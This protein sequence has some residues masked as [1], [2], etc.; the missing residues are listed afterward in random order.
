MTESLARIEDLAGKWMKTAES[1]D[2]VIDSVLMEQLLRM[3]PENVRLFVK[4]R[5][6]K[7]SAE[8][9][10]LADDYI[11]ARKE[12]ATNAKV[13]EKSPEKQ[14]P[15]PRWNKGQKNGYVTRDVKQKTKTDLEKTKLET[16]RRSK[17]DLKNLECF[18]MTRGTMHFNVQRMHI[19]ARTAERQRKTATVKR[20]GLV[21]GKP[22]ERILLDTGC[23]KTLVRQELIPKENILE[24]EAVTIRC[25]HRDTVLYPV[26]KV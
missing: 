14:S 10:K 13:E 21:E 7:T 17:R 25:A 24:E 11:V 6:P 26:A 4:E 15:A 9:S 20:K 18:V 22:V 2:E 1:K 19:S 8:A 23:S 16:P 12:D 3:L 5:K